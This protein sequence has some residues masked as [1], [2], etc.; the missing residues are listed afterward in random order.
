MDSPLSAT[1][2]LPLASWI[3]KCLPP[4]AM[5]KTAKAGQHIAGFTLFH[6]KAQQ[7]VVAAPVAAG[8]LDGRA[9]LGALDVEQVAVSGDPQVAVIAL[10]TGQCDLARK[11]DRRDRFG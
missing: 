11:Q 6:I 9:R 10:G 4:D 7:T 8:R 2:R 1:A 3:S 5:S